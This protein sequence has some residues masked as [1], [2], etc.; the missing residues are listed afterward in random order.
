MTAVFNRAE[1]ISFMPAATDFITPKTGLTADDLTPFVQQATKGADDGELFIENV[2]S[3]S[4]VLDDGE[5]KSTSFNNSHGF[6]LRRVVDEFQAYVYGNEVNKDTLK[7]AAGELAAAAPG[8]GTL[9]VSPGQPEKSFYEA[10]SPL[11]T[12]YDLPK[13]IKLAQDIDAYLRGKDNRVRQVKVVISGTVQDVMIVRPDGHVATDRRPMTVLFVFVTM[14]DGKKRETGMS[15]FI[16]RKGY[17]DIFNV[18]Q[19]VADKA[20]KQTDTLMQSIACPAGQMPVILGAG[21][22]GVIFHEA[23]GHGLE[24]D[25]IREG[26]V[27]SGKMGQQVAS[28]GVSIVDDG[29]IPNSRGSINIDDEGTPSQYTTLIE[30]GK[31][32]GYINDRLNGRIHGTGSTGNGRRQSYRHRP[33][34]RMRNTYMLNGDMTPEEIIASTKGKAVYAVDYSGG[35]VDTSS[36]KFVFQATEAYLVEDGKIVAPVKGATL[37]GSCAEGL[38]NIDMI[39]NDMRLEEG[40]TCGKKGQGMPVN[41]GMPTI[42]MTKGVTIGGTEG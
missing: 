15:K 12:D 38:K 13:R 37:I 22:S 31:L 41:D 23:I 8:N 34:V 40:G 4:V 1:S 30:N 11:G 29:T 9:D 39:G 26:S 19:D 6:G 21:G 5:I 16:R 42:R 25:L 24:G 20:Y 2:L 10:I 35:Q 3:E 36:G 32:V 7:K 14:D 33:L 18:W 28:E 17:S 27:F